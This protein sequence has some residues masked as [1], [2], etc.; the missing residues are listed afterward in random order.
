MVVR[1]YIL[2]KDRRGRE[3][4]DNKKNFPPINLRVALL[5]L[6]MLKVS[7]S[8]WLNVQKSSVHLN[9]K[10]HYFMSLWTVALKFFKP[11]DHT[12]N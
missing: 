6:T 8:W 11:E 5:S 10:C 7:K 9:S 12:C 4:L 1:A 3:N 2:H